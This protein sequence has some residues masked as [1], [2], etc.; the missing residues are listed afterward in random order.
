MYNRNLLK[1][2]SE[3]LEGGEVLEVDEAARETMI[4]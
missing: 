3:D 4:K 1:R 2:A